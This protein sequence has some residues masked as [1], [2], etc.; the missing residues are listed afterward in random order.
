MPRERKG[1]VVRDKLKDKTINDI[2]ILFETKEEKQERKERGI[3][4]EL[5]R[6]EQLIIKE[7]RKF[8]EQGEKD[9]YEP[10]RV[11]NFGIIIT[12]NMRA[13]VIKIET[14]H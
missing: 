8:F 2:S 14:Y 9:Y 13:M 4:K 5:L 10:K 6:M 7:I 12:M 11:S 1:K 3:M